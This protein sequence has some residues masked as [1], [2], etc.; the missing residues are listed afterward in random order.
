MQTK[1]LAHRGSSAYAPENTLAAFKLA[2]EQGADGIELDVHFTKDQIP[3]VTHDDNVLRVTGYNGLVKELTLEEIK[4]LSFD[5]KMAAYY[6]EKAPTLEEVLQLI[7]PS[8][9]MINIELKTNHQRP[10]G[11]EDACQELVKKYGTEDRILYSSFNHHSLNHIKT[12]APN[13][14][15][16]ILYSDNMFKEWNYAKT[17]N[18]E[19]I[20][21]HFHSVY[22]KEYI[23]ECQKTGIACNTWTVDNP[24]DIQFL[25][26]LGVDSIITNVPDVALALRDKK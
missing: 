21:P 13:M 11:L 17:M 7:K 22:G 18:W 15:C 19:A 26:D 14:P 3:L 24:K 12:I 8:K 6:G 2:I 9:L 16:G 23:E 1:I 20:H 5:N 10:E 25:L 4:K